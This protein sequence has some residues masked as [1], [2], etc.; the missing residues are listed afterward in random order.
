[1][2]YPVLLLVTAV[3][4]VTGGCRKAPAGSSQEAISA[5]YARAVADGQYGQHLTPHVHPDLD[6]TPKF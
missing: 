2:R 6:V 1:M 5:A 3:L 4:I